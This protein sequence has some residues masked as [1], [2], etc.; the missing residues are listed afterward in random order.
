MM[1]FLQ[2]GSSS[3]FTG[4]KSYR[5]RTYIGGDCISPRRRRKGK[6]RGGRGKAQLANEPLWEGLDSGEDPTP[7]PSVWRDVLTADHL[8]TGN[9]TW[10]HKSTGNTGKYERNT[11]VFIHFFLISSQ[12][13]RNKHNGNRE[14]T[15]RDQM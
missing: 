12:H 15:P 2:K 7:R 8:E 9:R 3:T 4:S 14:Q 11:G 5:A 6:E 10:A 1:S 13:E